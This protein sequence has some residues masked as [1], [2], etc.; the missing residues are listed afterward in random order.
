[1][2]KAYHN[3][4]EAAIMTVLAAC[5]VEENSF[6]PGSD[7]EEPGLIVLSGE[8]SQIYQTRARTSKVTCQKMLSSRYM[9]R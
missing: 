4:V 5:S 6:R 9:G 2:K 8:I 7:A 1:M 3:I